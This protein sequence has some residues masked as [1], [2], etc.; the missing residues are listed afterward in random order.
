MLFTFYL[1]DGSSALIWGILCTEI[2]NMQY[3]RMPEE[4]WVVIMTL[5]GTRG[6]DTM[7][8]GQLPYGGEIRGEKRGEGVE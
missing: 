8:R 3:W 1:I 7:V 6:A 2:V 5:G 4:Y